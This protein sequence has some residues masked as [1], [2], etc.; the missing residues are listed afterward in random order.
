MPSETPRLLLYAI[1]VFFVFL[2]IAALSAVPLI[3]FVSASSY[4]PLSVW[5][6]CGGGSANVYVDA[7][8]DLK[9]TGCIALDSGLF[10]PD[11]IELGD[12]SKGS[13]DVC[14]FSMDADVSMPLRF[15]VLYNGRSQRIVCQPGNSQ[16]VPDA[17]YAD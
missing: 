3:L 12:L 8:Q 6:E 10:S 9:N 7:Q 16:G 5:S 13:R 2:G 17:G 11:K 14:R 15:D 4:L 1:A